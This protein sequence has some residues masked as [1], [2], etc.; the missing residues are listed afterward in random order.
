MS[1]AVHI[2]VERANVRPG[3]VVQRGEPIGIAGAVMHASL[4]GVVAAIERRPHFAD[5]DRAALHISIEPDQGSD[6]SRIVDI[7]LALPELCVQAGVVGLGGGGFPTANKLLAA[8]GRVHTVIV[9]IMDTDGGADRA[10]ASE[11]LDTIDNGA[12]RVARWLGVER[13]IVA[14]AERLPSRHEASVPSIGEP[15]GEERRLVEGVLGTII[16][17]SERPVDHGVLVLNAAT[18]HAIAQA[19]RGQVVTERLVDLDGEPTW[20][21]IGAPL[22][23]GLWQSGGALSGRRLAPEATVRKTTYAL[24][25]ARNPSSAPCIRCGACRPACPANLL[26][27]ELYH[28]H[29][30]PDRLPALDLAACLACG[31]C[32]AVCPSQLPLA[33]TF[34]RAQRDARQA[35]QQRERAR[36]S[37]ARFEQR[38]ARL[39]QRAAE[40]DARRQARLA[41]LKRRGSSR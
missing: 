21:P 41:R 2:A 39:A 8:Q 40:R 15:R 38:S 32:D 7:D 17:R 10:L 9:N 24:S 25:P 29:N 26:P 12:E 37:E 18:C 13:V 28:W 5:E 4:S 34:Q 27:D 16:K 6:A 3:Q 33:P 19:A 30:S 22:P 1:Q 11:A 31:L 35:A 14:A 20:L 23:S 36:L